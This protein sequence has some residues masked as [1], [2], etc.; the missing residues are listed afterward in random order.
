MD[1]ASDGESPTQGSVV[2]IDFSEEEQLGS[3][4]KKNP[5]RQLVIMMGKNYCRMPGYQCSTKTQNY[6]MA[7]D[8]KVDITNPKKTVKG[9][10]LA[11]ELDIGE[12]ENLVGKKRPLDSVLSLVKVEE[13]YAPITK[14]IKSCAGFG[15]AAVMTM[16]IFFE[17][18]ED[19]NNY[20]MQQEFAKSMLKDLAFLFLEVGKKALE[21]HGLLQSPFILQ[22]FTTHLNSI[23]GAIDV[24]KHQVDGTYSNFSNMEKFPP[25]GALAMFA[26]AVEHVFTLWENRE[27]LW[28]PKDQ[29]TETRMDEAVNLKLYAKP[30]PKLNKSTG[31]ETATHNRFLDMN[32][33]STTRKYYNSTKSLKVSSLE[34]ITHKA[35]VFT[36]RNTE[37]T[38]DTHTNPHE[39]LVNI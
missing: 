35:L 31:K 18:K 23:D 30:L 37:F 19:F 13:G 32:W 24:E 4:K 15:S 17:S 29:I 20:E 21:H 38:K 6:K 1:V 16:E 36:K 33:G 11:D 2:V 28:E 12:H 25:R 10:A 26:A 39:C 7:T 34:E 5:L 3:G 14:H 22:T 9:L 27:I 8:V